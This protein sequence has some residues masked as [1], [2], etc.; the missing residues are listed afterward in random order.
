M[1]YH[2]L[3]S[4]FFSYQNTD[5]TAGHPPPETHTRYSLAIIDQPILWNFSLF[6]YLLFISMVNIL[7]FP[8]RSTLC[9]LGEY[10]GIQQ[11]MLSGCFLNYAI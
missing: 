7:D 1:K 5:H 4:Q 6:G 2:I 8:E 10:L 11:Y 9:F 3:K